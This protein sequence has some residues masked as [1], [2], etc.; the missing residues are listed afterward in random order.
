MAMQKKYCIVTGAGS[1]IGKSTAELFLEK[2]FTCICIDQDE[3]N[4]NALLPGHPEKYHLVYD[5]LDDNSYGQIACELQS[6][7][8]NAGFITLINNL[9]GSKPNSS[10][11]NVA[12]WDRFLSSMI[13]NVKPTACMTDVVVSHMQKI[14]CGNILNIS[15]ISGRV[16]HMTIK[17]DY[18]AA[19]AAILGFSRVKAMELSKDGILVNTLCPGII[20]TERIINRWESR[21]QKYNEEILKTIPLGRLGQP[22]EVAKAAYFLG[23]DDNSY[24]TGAVLDINGGIFML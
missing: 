7:L 23:S 6:I 5:L 4:L 11:L 3:A 15:S 1:G 9:G 12:D 10:P 22:E 21:E 18:A 19:K 13:F 17:E 2:G 20:A 8:V 24:I 14:K 16:P